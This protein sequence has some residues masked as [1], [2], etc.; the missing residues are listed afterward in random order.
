TTMATTIMPNPWKHLIYKSHSEVNQFAPAMG[1]V[2]P[3]AVTQNYFCWNQT[4]GPMGIPW[5]FVEFAGADTGEIMYKVS[6]DGSTSPQH[7]G[8]PAPADGSTWQ[9]AGHSIT[10]LCLMICWGFSPA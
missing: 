7:S 6:G 1:A 8:A 4:W 2:V 10:G 5:A 3:N 9:V